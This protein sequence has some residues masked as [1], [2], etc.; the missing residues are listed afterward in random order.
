MYLRNVLFKNYGALKDVKYDFQFNEN[1]TPKPTVFIGKNGVGKTLLLSNIAHSLI[2]I[3]RN[4]YQEISDVIGQSYY[5][6]GSKHY[7]SSSENDAYSKMTFDN[8]AYY[9]DLMARDYDDFKSHF[10]PK[11]YNGVDI[12]DKNLKDNGFYVKTQKPLVNVFEQEIFL[13]FPV[14]RYY[15][16]TWE[17]EKNYSSKFV[18][19]DTNYVGKCNDSIIQ[20]NLLENVESWLLDVAIDQALYENR[21]LPV[22]V[23]NGDTPLTYR[24]TAGKNTNIINA[25][26]TLLKNIY[27]NKYSSMRFVIVPKQHGRRQIQILGS[28][29]NEGENLVVPRFANLSSG[30]IMLLGMMASILREYDKFSTLNSMTFEAISGVVLIDEIDLHLHS[31]LL[32]T[33]LP[34]LISMFPK[35][36]FIVTS[37]SPFFLLGMKNK[38]KDSCN[39]VTLPTGTITNQIEHFDEI[40]R[41]YSIIDE[42]YKEVLN[43]LDDVN[44]KLDKVSKPLIIT[45]GKTDWKHIKHALSC[46]QKK[47]MFQDVNIEFLEYEYELGDSKLESLLDNLAKIPQVHKIIGVFDCDTKTGKKYIDTVDFGNNVYGCC[48]TDVHGYGDDISIELLYTRD[49]LK[50]CD[51]NGRRIYL[52]EEFKE[53]SHQLKTNSQITCSNSAIAGAYKSGIVKIIDSNVFDSEEKSLALSK[54]DFADNVYNEKGNFA[55]ISVEGFKNIIELI[56]EICNN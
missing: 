53:K 35:I 27:M 16:P 21:A 38:F 6:V 13:Y 30:E 10:D 7:I 48:I 24:I 36:Q 46:L 22:K 26:N 1:G 11:M 51:K 15:I 47:G 45:E 54:S 14:E 4:F 31:D 50:R 56:Q 12:Y 42:S 37:H 8:D 28:V 20:Y 49:D 25:I 52:S 44:K 2:E 55:D 39:F 18:F 29:D 32:K 33:V 19:N 9:V 40:E 23:E 3:K 34:N 5:R 41:C 43:S 17:N